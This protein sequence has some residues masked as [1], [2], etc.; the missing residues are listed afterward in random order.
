MTGDMSSLKARQTSTKKTTTSEVQYPFIRV[1][2]G[3]LIDKITILQIQKKYSQNSSANSIEAEL[4]ILEQALCNLGSQINEA[5]IE[6]LLKINNDLWGK[7]KIADKYWQEKNIGEDFSTLLKNI[8][9]Q[10][11]LR[12][13][14]IES[15]N[16]KYYQ[17]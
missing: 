3:E 12:E 13:A 9:Q 6:Q 4:Y 17:K 1:S 2:P 11:K 16:E 8:Y 15:I 7:K 14:V 5:S 10:N